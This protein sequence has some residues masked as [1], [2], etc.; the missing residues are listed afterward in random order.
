MGLAGAACLFL[1]AALVAICVLPRRRAVTATPQAPTRTVNR[2][3]GT[4]S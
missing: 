4:P 3:E 1:L 2:L